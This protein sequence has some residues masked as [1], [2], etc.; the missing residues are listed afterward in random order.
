MTH[1][2]RL[3]QTTARWYGYGRY[4]QRKWT[5][6]ASHWELIGGYPGGL[7]I[8]RGSLSTLRYV[9]NENPKLSNTARHR[10]MLAA[11]LG[12]LRG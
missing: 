9:Y 4:G 2:P 5:L 10:L 1:G 7:P 3:G 12:G 11:V 6:C 8:P